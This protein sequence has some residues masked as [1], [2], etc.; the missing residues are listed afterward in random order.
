MRTTKV[1]RHRDN[2]RIWLEGKW[3]LAA[4]F[5]VDDRLTVEQARYTLRIS[6]NPEGDRKVSGKK[7]RTIPVIDI[8]CAD[9]LATLGADA[10]RATVE[11]IE[12]GTILIRRES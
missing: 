4:G 10:T 7:A 9:V 3:L 12:P 1:G 2:G 8:N 5:N 6:V 11:V